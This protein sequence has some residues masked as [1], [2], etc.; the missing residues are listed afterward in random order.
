[1]LCCRLAA[2]LP[3]GTSSKTV[4]Q[5][6]RF[7]PVITSHIAVVPTAHPQGLFP[8]V[9]FRTLAATFC[10]YIPLYRDLLLH[11]GRHNA[12]VL[13][14]TLISLVGTI[15]GV[16]CCRC[17]RCCAI[18]CTCHS[19]F[20]HVAYCCARRRYSLILSAL[21]RSIHTIS[22][23]VSRQQPRHCIATPPKMSCTCESALA[24]SSLRWRLVLHWCLCSHSYVPAC[25][26]P[27]S[28][29]ADVFARALSER[30][31]H[32]QSARC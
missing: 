27:S 25:L 31:Q 23:S 28:A 6:S 17:G 10:F 22:F 19:E 18:Q 15:C 24:L 20:G 4:N 1:M 29:W 26:F 9:H 12:F 32:I 14:Q 21:V 30:V 13:H 11:G 5:P 8:G 2:C 16:D 7:G 3:W